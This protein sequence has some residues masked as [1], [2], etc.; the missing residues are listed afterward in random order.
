MNKMLSIALLMIATHSITAI[1]T[2]KIDKAIEDSSVSKLKSALRGFEREEMAPQERMKYLKEFA[3]AALDRIELREESCSVVGNWQDIA[4]T[5]TGGVLALVGSFV[6]L[7]SMNFGDR[8]RLRARFGRNGEAEPLEEDE[9][10]SRRFIKSW[11]TFTGGLALL[12]GGSYLLYK[13]LTC[14]IQKAQIA[15]AQA[16][17]ELIQEKL[18][19]GDSKLASVG[20]NAS[21]T[22][23]A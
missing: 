14:S 13:G 4:K 7:N 10:G 19:A 8:D 22:E 5:A 15:Q 1:T 3:Q 18:V 6:S 20:N 11:P 21:K 9:A 16:I 12:A 23:R 2:N 17:E